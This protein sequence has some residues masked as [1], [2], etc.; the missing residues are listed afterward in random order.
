[1]R[2]AAILFVATA[3]L[4]AALLFQLRDPSEP[5]SDEITLFVFCAAGIKAPVEKVAKSYEEKFGVNIQLQYGGSGT[6][7]SNLEISNQGDIYIAGDSSYTDIALE[8]GLI[9][10]TLPLSLLQPVIAVPKGN[11]KNINHVE[12]LLRDGLRLSLANPD[13]ASVG[14]TSRKMLTKIGLWQSI[15]AAVQAN[16]VFKPTVNEVANDVK[17]N[18]VDAAIAWDVTVNQYDDLDAIPIRGSEGFIKHV[19]LGVLTRS[20]Q[21][22]EALRFAR[23]LAAPEKGGVLFEENGFPS[24]PGDPWA[25]TPEIIYYSGGINRLA[26]EETLASF[27]EREGVS[28]VTVYNGCGILLGQIKSGGEPDIYHT[29]DASFMKGVESQFG[30]AKNLSRTNIVIAVQK[31]NPHDI[32]SLEDLGRKKIQLGVCNEEQS[33]LGAMAADLLRKNGLYDSVIKNV[34]LNTPTADLLVAQLTVGKLDAAIVYDANTTYIKDKADVIPIDL[35]GSM[36]TQTIAIARQTAFPQIVNR[37][38]A[39]LRNAS[40]KERFM[41]NGFIWLP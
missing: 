38:E 29:C 15:N 14:K 24:V 21:S 19:T 36:A 3:T 28:I 7:L 6:L 4:I 12:D 13:A 26:I 11:P 22:V 23:Y 31:G 10:E 33:A 37:L 9:Q 18:A 2:R 1:M 39:A 8:K 35:E 5:D 16:G 25:E 40:S 27:Q 32:Q 30:V 34:V 17:L 41:D 20:K